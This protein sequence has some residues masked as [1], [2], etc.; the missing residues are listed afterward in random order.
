[1]QYNIVQYSAIQYSTTL[2]LK[3]MGNTQVYIAFSSM[4]ELLAFYTKE[5]WSTTASWS[6]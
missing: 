2:S 1:M 3:E 4:K 5:S 6:N